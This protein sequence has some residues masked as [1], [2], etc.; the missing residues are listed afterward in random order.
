MLILFNNRLYILY[1]NISAEKIQIIL[2]K[3]KQLSKKHQSKTNALTL[4]YDTLS[5]SYT[6]VCNVEFPY[7]KILLLNSN[8]FLFNAYT[9]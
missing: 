2:A 7:N 4:S 3:Y 9:F 8:N 6:V 1:S 5:A